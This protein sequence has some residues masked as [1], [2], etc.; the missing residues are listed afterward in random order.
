MLKDTQMSQNIN[1]FCKYTQSIV[2]R[3]E[4]WRKHLCIKTDS[5]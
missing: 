4:K 5:I 1:N 3:L 2:L